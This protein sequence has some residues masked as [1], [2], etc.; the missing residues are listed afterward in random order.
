MGKERSQEYDCLQHW[1]QHVKQMVRSKV[2]SLRKTVESKKYRILELNSVKE[3]SKEL[4]E[5][6]VFVP[7]DKAATYIIVVCKCY[8][9]EVI[10]KELGLWSSTTSGD[11]NI[12]ETMDPKEISGNHI[13]YM[14]SLGFKE[15]SLSDKFPSFYWTPKLHKTPYKH[16]FIASSIDYT[17]KPLSVLLNHILSAIKGKWSNLSSVIY[18]RTGINEMWILKNSSE[19][20]QK[21]NSFH[22][23]KTTSIQTF[24][25]STLYTFIPHQKLKDR[26]HMLVNQTFLY[27]NGSRRYKHLVVSEDGTFSTNEEASAG[28]N[29]DKTFICQMTDFLIDN[30]YI[31]IGNHLFRQC[32]G[33]PMGKPL[34]ANLF[35]YSY[36]VELLRSLKKSNK[37]F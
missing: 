12:P 24:D 30:I 16:R 26:I 33:I 21:M 19:L 34:L 5:K 10:S 4:Q 28:K 7:A 32:I 35:L 22:R 23:P 14:K 1:V 11:S 18:S 31:K 36:E 27:K 20:L 6:Y 9:L 13:S 25:F 8:Y 37:G 29:Y 15:D 3:C 2:N 17:T